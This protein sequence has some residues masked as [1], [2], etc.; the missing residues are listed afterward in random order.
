MASATGRV[1]DS[2]IIFTGKN[3]QSTWKGSNALPNTFYAVSESGWMTTE[4]FAV[5]FD[6]F[7]QHVTER[8]LL[9]IFDGHLTHILVA[10]I[11]KAIHDGIHIIKLPPHVTDKLQPL[12]V[13]CFSPLKGY[14]EKSLN[15][16]VSSFGTSKAMPKSMF[17]DLLCKIWHKGLTPSNIIS[18]F[19]RT[20]IYPLD[21]EKFP[22]ERLDARSLRRYT[23]WVEM[24]KPSDIF[25]EASQSVETP[26]KLK[27]TT[28][29]RNDNATENSFQVQELPFNSTP[30]TNVTITNNNDSSIYNV[31]S[32]SSTPKPLS[33]NT[34]SLVN[35]ECDCPLSRRIG[36]MPHKIPG[37]VW[38]PAWTL[39]DEEKS[40]E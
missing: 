35:H 22:I 3:F 25:E 4:I 12:D 11:E 10:V 37:K 6:L 40:F 21:T 2:L 1:L 27:P 9:L 13:T 38:V 24:G 28:E 29:E 26:Q 20:G 17:I 16:F 36:P 30:I 7:R 23:K 33:V 34:T 14:W 39:H 31:A 19:K 15:D 32:N 18:G 8:P 5:W